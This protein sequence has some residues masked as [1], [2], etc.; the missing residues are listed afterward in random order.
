MILIE[1]FRYTWSLPYSFLFTLVVRFV[2][3]NG[4]LYSFSPYRTF[5]T[6][7]RSVFSC[8]EHCRHCFLPVKYM[9]AIMSERPRPESKGIF[10]FSRVL[11]MFSCSSLF[12]SG[13]SAR[14]R[15]HFVLATALDAF[16]FIRAISCSWHLLFH[17]ISSNSWI[18]EHLFFDNGGPLLFPVV[19]IVQLF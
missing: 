8:E 18:Y 9:S 2:D 10:P 6:S 16:H 5:S 14:L 1:G 13:P 12:N 19:L 7:E 15:A 4:F 11:L 17:W 3:E